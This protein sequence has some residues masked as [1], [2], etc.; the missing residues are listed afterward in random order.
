MMSRSNTNNIT[1]ISA[2][3]PGVH[4]ASCL[5]CCNAPSCCALCGILPCCNDPEYI[6]LNRESSKYVYIRENSIEWNDPQIIMKHGPLFGVDPC[7]YDIRDNVKVLYYD[8]PIFDRITDKV[9]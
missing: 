3:K 6:I 9:F 4:S 7:M 5:V 1:V 2:L 8:D